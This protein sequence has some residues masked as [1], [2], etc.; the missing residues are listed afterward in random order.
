MKKQL[1]TLATA[2]ALSTPTWA[3]A[4]PYSQSFDTK[5]AFN[6]MTL[7]HADTDTHD[8]DYSSSAARFYPGT[9]YN[10][11]NAWFFTPSLDLE[12]GK[13]YVI[14]FTTWI[15]S[16]GS[17]NYKDLYVSYG[18]DCTAESQTQV[19]MENI[20]SSTHTAKKLTITP[21]TTGAYNIGFHTEASSGSSNDILVDDILIKEYISLPGKATDVTATPGEKG[22]LSVTLSWT[23]PSVNDG[24]SAL[25]QLSGAKIYRTDSSWVT[26]GESNLI[27]TITD[28][29]APGQTSTWT[30]NTIDKPGTYYYNIVPFND[31]GNSSL[32][33]DK[34]KTAYVGPDTNIGATKNVVASAVEGNDKAITLTWDAPTGTNGGYIDPAAVAWKITRKGAET[35]VL[36][37]AWSGQPPY[38]YTD[39][40][41]PGLAAYTYTVQYIYNDKTETTGAT[42]NAIAAGGTAALPY[43]ETFPTTTISPIYTQLPANS[44]GVASGAAYFASTSSVK[45][46]WLLTPPFELK[47]GVAYDIDYQTWVSSATYPKQVALT[48]GKEATAE[49]Q[50][51]ILADENISNTSSY[52]TTANKSVRYFAEEDG[53]VYFGFHVSGTAVTGRTSIDNISI[54]EVKVVP[55]AA[56]DFTATPDEDDELAVNLAWTNPTNDNLGNALSSIDKIEVYR[57]DV[58]IKK[59]INAEPGKQ[60]TLTDEGIEK[61]GIYTYKIIAYLGQNPGE[62]ATASSGLVG[63]PILLPYTPDFS[64]AES[65]D[66]WS[67]PAT[68]AGDKW[69]Y[70]ALNSRLEAPNKDGLWLFTP[71]FKAQQGT[72]TL[73]LNAAIYLSSYPETVIIALYKDANPSAEPITEPITHKFTSTSKTD[74]E[75]T[76]DVAEE[77]KYYI[78]ISRPKTAR[79]LYLYGVSI[80]QTK[81]INLNAPLAATDLTATGDN[82]DESKVNLSWTNPTLT[83]GGADLTEITKVEVLRDGEVIATLDGNAESYVDM[84]DEAGKYTYSVIVYNGDDA[85]EP[86]TVTTGFVGGAYE[87]PYDPDFTQAATFDTWSFVP[88]E[89]GSVLKYIDS[90]DYLEA[91]ANN[92]AAETPMFKA[93]KGTINLAISAKTS[94]YRYPTKLTVN[95]LSQSNEIVATE[96]YEFTNVSWSETKNLEATIPA[97][98]KYYVQI[99]VTDS[100]NGTFIDDLSVEQTSVVEP[101][102]I[103]WDNTDACYATPA[104][105][106]DGGEPVVMTCVWDGTM[107]SAARRAAR[108]IFEKDAFYAEIPG[109]AKSVKFLDAENPE[110]AVEIENPEHN[111]IY[112][113][114]GTSEVYDPDNVTAIEAVIAESADAPVYF[115]LQGARV[116]H[117]AVGQPYI[118]VRAGKVTKEIVK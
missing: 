16:S 49:A 65:F 6:T 22:V 26:M 75:F 10:S 61:A 104:V 36:E 105:S 5:D 74:A 68:S 60:M 25:N 30:D 82:D 64:S 72:V 55:E 50:T 118:V 39:A 42:S 27:A 32:T 62:E 48:V 117:P 7:W 34:I 79:I 37:E 77:G 103:W 83:V 96:N 88:N 80:E 41:L 92:V 66:F 4:L 56:K 11:Y 86:A 76:F 17:S 28:G 91:Y 33:P 21:E 116:A 115:N 19:W 31:N 13:T 40:N 44:W 81:V 18:T 35:V 58:I 110:A 78:G 111:R 12:A 106:V 20:Q 15:S 14:T 3:D 52:A 94:T 98:G 89:K 85:S 2:L 47:K 113:A 8:W 87:L 63:G 38:L 70:N 43:S 45:E 29:V 57:G 108:K 102:T 73:K 109:D 53:V 1:L 59:Y 9:R 46:G 100:G 95:V 51:T 97:E 114:D 24:G 93:K 84:L 69:S 90:K 107:P 101:I 54:K 67:M 71:Q 112:K 23:N 99:I